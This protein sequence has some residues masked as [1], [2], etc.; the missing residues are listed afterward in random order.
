[1][2]I[3][4][5]LEKEFKQF[6]RNPFMPRLAI[7]FPLFIILVYPWVTT[8]EV[9]NITVEVVDNDQS[10]LSQRLITKIGASEYFILKGVTNNYPDALTSIEG[11]KSDII[12]D[13]PKDF[14]K[15][16]VMRNNPD[17]QISANAVNGIKGSIGSSYLAQIV[18]EHI[19]EYAT[20]HGLELKPNAN[21]DELN[22]FNPTMDYKR[23]MI[24]ALMTMI[25][26]MMCG[27]L[28]ALNIVSEK[29]I[30]TIEQINVTP[31][32]KWNFILAKLI[33]YWLMGFL[34]LTICFILTA[35][36]YG[37]TAQGNILTIYFAATLFILVMSG[38]GLL[39]S[40]ISNTMQQAMFVMFFVVMVSVLMSGLFTPIRSMPAWAQYITYVIPPR[41]FV[42]IMRSVFLKG[43]GIIENWFNFSALASL[44]ILVN[45]WAV[46]SY[47]KQ[48]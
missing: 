22:L 24:P 4:Y 30:G 33:P 3:K 11:S 32:S 19:L 42:E 37:Y 6:M 5:L 41:Y 10:P 15:S 2:Q 7:M 34:I 14:E 23:F 12:L 13:I 26:I 18:N 16:I 43:G 27:F 46:I 44:A 39:I 8:F 36:V 47:R 28:P 48:N 17:I 20:A 21:F 45:L 1:M 29:E 35:I 40:N 9:K 25:I 38:L 31:I